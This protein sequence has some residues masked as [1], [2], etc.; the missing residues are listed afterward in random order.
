MTLSIPFTKLEGLGN[1]FVLI[2]DFYPGTG[3]TPV[4]PAFARILLDRRFGIGG[5]Q[6]LWLKPSRD[7]QSADARMEI[8]NPDGSTAEM[9][10]NGIRAFAIYFHKRAKQPRE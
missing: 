4:T 8:L 5:D 9:C 3:K 2:D 6:L 1:D 7:P 10:G